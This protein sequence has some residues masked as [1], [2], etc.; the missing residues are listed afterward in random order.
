M[1]KKSLNILETIK[2]FANVTSICRQRKTKITFLENNYISW[3]LMI[4][5]TFLSLRYFEEICNCFQFIL[6]EKQRKMRK[7]NVSGI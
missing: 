4:S 5:K 1:R 3:T 6:E 2:V 7:I